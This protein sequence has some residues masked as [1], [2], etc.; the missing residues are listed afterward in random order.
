MPL[1]D[2]RCVLCSSISTFFTR[3]ISAQVEPVCRR[4]GD[5]EMTRLVSSF[6]YHRSLQTIHEQ[7]G[8]PTQ[9]ATD[10]DHYK[11]PRN[12]GRHLEQRF[13]Q[14]GMEVPK[15]VRQEIDSAREGVMPAGLDS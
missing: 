11:D 12:I 14:L 7:S 10:L 8:P 2:Y 9:S 6:A 15:E 5:K 13:E 1:Y 4:C 3:S